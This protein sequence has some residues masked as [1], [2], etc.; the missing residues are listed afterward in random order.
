MGHHIAAFFYGP[1][2]IVGGLIM[3]YWFVGY[4]FLFGLAMIIILFGIS[5]FSSKKTILYN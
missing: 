5:F 3:M 1:F 4:S 2:Q